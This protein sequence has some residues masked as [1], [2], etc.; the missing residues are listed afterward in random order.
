MGMLEVDAPGK[1][2][3]GGVADTIKIPN[4]T[5]GVGLLFFD[6]AKKVGTGSVIVLP[7][8]VQ[9]IMK[10]MLGKMEEKG[11]T[12]GSLSAKLAGGADFL[13]SSMGSR[14]S[15][16]VMDACGQM[17]IKVSGKDLGGKEK[18]TLITVLASGETKVVSV[19][20]EKKI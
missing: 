20:G 19:S 17:G 18:R 6:Q 14:I 15:Q 8:V 7:P 13:Q 2:V 1:V 12:A 11:A 9:K 16:S 10:D 4:I 5:A 3:V